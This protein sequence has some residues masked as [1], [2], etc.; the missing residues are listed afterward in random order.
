MLLVLH[1]ESSSALVHVD[2]I[3]HHLFCLDVLLNLVVKT[4]LPKVSLGL[5]TEVL[6][7]HFE[8]VHLPLDLDF[9]HFLPLVLLAQDIGFFSHMDLLD[10]RHFHAL[11]FEV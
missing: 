1:F 7:L 2:L 9:F 5:D 8:R 4:D 6:G 11:I 10:A 3:L